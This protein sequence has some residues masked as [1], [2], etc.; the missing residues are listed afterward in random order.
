MTATSTPPARA[1]PGRRRADRSPVATAPGPDTGTT[2]DTALRYRPELDGVRAIAVYL[3]VAYHAGMSGVPGGFLGVDLFFVLSGFLV[4]GVILRE[5]DRRGTFS[6]GGF[7]ARR[8]RRLLPAAVLV[9][10]VTSLVQLLLTSQATRVGLVGDARAAL[11]YVANWHFVADSRDYFAQADD[12]SPFLHF[13]SLAIEEQF[14][15]AFPLLVLAV[16]R[17]APRPVRALA[18]AVAVVGAVSLGLQLLRAG[19]DATYAYY[20]TDTRV[21]QLAA[22][23][24][25]TLVVRRL[26]G[27]RVEARLARVATPAAVVGLAGLLVLASPAA[28]LDP[29]ARGIGATVA[30]VLLLGGLWLAPRGPLA[31]V[32]ALPAP[33]WLLLTLT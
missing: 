15:L 16:L 6:L 8:V 25:L 30:A 14:Y 3:V 31:R 5:T 7:Y 11:L 20:A 13:W 10:V 22:G 29:S 28:D 32:L 33:R 12:P 17:W 26:R 2:A 4:T 18:V 1:R 9:V 27:R 24:A 23:V 19:D 21:Y